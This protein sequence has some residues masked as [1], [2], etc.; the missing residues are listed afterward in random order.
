MFQHLLDENIFTKVICTCS[1][2]LATGSSDSSPGLCL[3][4][5]EWQRGNIFFGL[6]E[7]RF[8]SSSPAFS[9]FLVFIFFLMRGKYLLKK[10]F[11]L[12]E[13]EREHAFFL[14]SICLFVFIYLKIRMA[15]V[16]RDLALCW[17]TNQALGTVWAGS[18]WSQKWG[19]N[20]VFLCGW[21]G[22]KYLDHH[23]LL[24]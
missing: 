12:L 11:Y 21:Q 18:G 4:K 14:F 13:R 6:W 22:L 2:C 7:Q 8:F 17:F 5:G 1:W 16:G 9:Y 3:S 20:P 19:M 15:K 10:K 23:P 24:P